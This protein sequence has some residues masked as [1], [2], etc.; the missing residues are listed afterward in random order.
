MSNSI[1]PF[2]TMNLDPVIEF[3]IILGVKIQINN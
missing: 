3:A 2:I 1:F